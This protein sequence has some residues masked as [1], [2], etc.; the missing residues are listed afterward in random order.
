M[1][2]LPVVGQGTAG[3]LSTYIGIAKGLAFIIRSITQRWAC[4]QFNPP[5]GL[6]LTSGGQ[7][8]PPPSAERIGSPWQ[9]KNPQRSGV[10][11]ADHPLS[12]W[13]W[14]LTWSKPLMQCSIEALSTI[15]PRL[16]PWPL[17]IR[18]WTTKQWNHPISPWH[19]PSPLPT[20]QAEQGNPWTSMVTSMI[21]SP[22]RIMIAAVP[23][24]TVGE[25]DTVTAGAAE[26]RLQYT[27]HT[28]TRD[29]E[30][31][32]K[33]RNLERCPVDRKRWVSLQHC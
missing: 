18:A 17:I 8:T 1:P 12:G 28:N 23:S 29:H 24:V 26:H 16:R 9:L 31:L 11:P 5:P 30:R 32:G 21:T 22:L 3:R 6:T 33:L 25:L 7:T 2:Y 14:R 20:W 19:S 10:W 13:T 4:S 27:Q 15:T